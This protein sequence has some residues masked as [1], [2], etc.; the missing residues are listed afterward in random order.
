MFSRHGMPHTVVSDNGPQFS[1]TEYQLYAAEYGFK[2]AYSNPLFSQSNGQ[3]EQYVQTIK[4]MLKKAVMDNSDINIAI[5]DYR[6]T[7]L[8]G[9]KASRVQLLTN[10][11]SQITS[12]TKPLAF[13][14]PNIKENTDTQNSRQTKTLL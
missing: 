8:M 2:P 4:R 1:S 13:R 6:N 7:F 12:K 10:W 14:N 9:I 3:I 11:R 5:L